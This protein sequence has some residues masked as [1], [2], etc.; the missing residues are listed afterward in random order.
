MPHLDLEHCLVLFSVE[1]VGDQAISRVLTRLG[2]ET[3]H[4]RR[5]EILYRRFQPERLRIAH[6][7]TDYVA[8]SVGDLGRARVKLYDLHRPVVWRD[9]LP[10]RM[11]AFQQ[12]PDV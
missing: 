8:L 1:P 9:R 12:P 10:P 7:V 3:P 11:A 4:Q 6:S 2:P 5:R